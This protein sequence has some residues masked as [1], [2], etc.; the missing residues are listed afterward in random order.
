LNAPLSEIAGAL[1]DICW[2]L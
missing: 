1:Q 2:M